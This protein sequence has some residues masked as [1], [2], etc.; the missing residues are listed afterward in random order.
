MQAKNEI[1]YTPAPW[2]DYGIKDGDICGNWPNDGGCHQP[3]IECD[4][5]VYG[6]YGADRALILAAPDMYEALK[7]LRVMAGVTEENW[8][9]LYKQAREM[10]DAALAKVEGAC[11]E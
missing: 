5:G 11:Y 10:A 7:F 1:K 8:Q 6:P 9:D 4:S 2:T 3:I